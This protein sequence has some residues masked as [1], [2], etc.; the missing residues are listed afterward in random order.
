MAELSS[1]GNTALILEF[2]ERAHMALKIKELRQKLLTA[3][4]KISQLESEK[5]LDI[6]GLKEEAAA[7]VTSLA[8]RASSSVARNQVY[9]KYPISHKVHTMLM[10]KK[11]KKED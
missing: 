9:N 6:E 3:E 7:M 1:V 5:D 2:E 8:M 4:S 10:Y 11:L